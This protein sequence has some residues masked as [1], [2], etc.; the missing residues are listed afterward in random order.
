MIYFYFFPIIL[1]TNLLILPFTYYDW[2]Q[3]KPVRIDSFDIHSEHNL[4]VDENSH[5]GYLLDGKESATTT[6][7]YGTSTVFLSSLK[8]DENGN[9]LM[10]GNCPKIKIPQDIIDEKK[11]EIE[12]QN[13]YTK[14]HNE[15]I[16]TFLSYWYNH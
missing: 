16:K 11:K 2:L 3:E 6:M 7:S 5:C 13:E 10:W 9:F 15:M 4:Y 8:K 12:A 14:Q 1:I